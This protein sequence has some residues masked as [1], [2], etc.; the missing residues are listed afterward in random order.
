[1]SQNEIVQH[2]LNKPLVDK[3]WVHDMRAIW[4]VLHFA[5]ALYGAVRRVVWDR[6]ANHSP[7][8]DSAIFFLL[9]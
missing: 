3:Q 5:T 6:G 7:G 8:P 9:E 4:I 1:M 2:A